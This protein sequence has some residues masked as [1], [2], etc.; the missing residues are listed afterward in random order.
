MGGHQGDGAVAGVSGVCFM[1]TSGQQSAS[2]SR[3][4]PNRCLALA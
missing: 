1:L 2:G 4:M 3:T